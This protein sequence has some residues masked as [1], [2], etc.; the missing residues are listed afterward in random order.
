MSS[1]AVRLILE[2][3]LATEWGSRTPIHWD[4][5]NDKPVVGVAF[6]R[7]TLDGIDSEP[8]SMN[9]DRDFDLFTIQVLTPK[10]LGSENSWELSDEVA[11]I[12]RRYSEGTL[13]VNKVVN[14]RVGKHDEWYQ[15]NVLVDTQ[16]DNFG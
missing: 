13:V 16:Y 8:I 14:E 4:D 10:G 5:T 7:C 11:R 1:D 2:R 6:I 12:F 3:R 9:C 15:R